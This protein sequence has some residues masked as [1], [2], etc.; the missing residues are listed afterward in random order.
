M[1]SRMLFS[2]T[3]LKVKKEI[4]TI[5]KTIYSGV[6][7]SLEEL[8]EIRKKG[9]GTIVF[10][11]VTFTLFEDCADLC[12]LQSIRKRSLKKRTVDHIFDWTKKCFSMLF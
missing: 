2:K 3:K 6:H 4:K 12:D 8:T 11:E 9:D 1:R 5:K 7:S 10:S